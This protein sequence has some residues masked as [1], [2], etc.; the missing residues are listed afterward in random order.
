MKAEGG[1][2]MRRGFTLIELLIVVAIIGILA[3]IAIPNFLQA[4][5]RAK[6]ARVESDQRNLGLAMETYKV[7]NNYYPPASYSDRSTRRPMWER[8]ASLTT[9]VEYVKS[10]PMDVFSPGST[11]WRMDHP[12]YRDAYYNY[13]ERDFSL[14]KSLP[15]GPTAKEKNALWFIN[16]FGP[17]RQN[18]ETVIT[19]PEGVSW[20][21]IRYDPTNGTISGGDI[22]RFGP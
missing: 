17:N 19:T 11:D 16:G 10:I 18:D 6:I 13:F 4:Q 2:S 9:P 1:E 3:A 14:L 5:T 20:A 7:D 22:C 21:I 15:W 8:F 12:L